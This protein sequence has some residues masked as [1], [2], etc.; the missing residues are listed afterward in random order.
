MRPL[1]RLFLVPLFI[2]IS[3]SI[4]FAQAPDWST[5]SSAG[6]TGSDRG[7]CVAMDAAG[8]SY[9]AGYFYEEATFGSITLSSS[10]YKELF[11]AKMAPNGVW[12]WAVKAG[13]S[14]HSEITAIAVD[15]AGNAY[16]TG[17]YH[18]TPDFG[19]HSFTSTAYGVDI[20]V[21]KINSSGTWQWAVS[22]GGDSEPEK[23]TD[24]ALDEA[25]N[26]YVTGFFQGTAAFGSTSLSS[27]G[28]TDIFIAKLTN[29]GTW[30]G[31]LG[32]GGPGPDQGYT[33]ASDISSNIFVSGYYSGSV[34]FG[35]TQLNSIGS[36]DIFVTKLDSFLSYL[37]AATASG[38]Y[39]SDIATDAAGSAYLSSGSEEQATFGSLNI[40]GGMFLIKID[41]SGAWTW[42]EAPSGLHYGVGQGIAIDAEDNIYWSGGFEG[43]VIFGS[44]TLQ[45]T[46]DD[47]ALF[48]AKLSNNGAWAWATQSLGGWNLTA[49]GLSVNDDHLVSI[50][51]GFYGS[52]QF[53]S[54]GLTAAGSRDILSLTLADTSNFTANFS[55]S[56]NNGPA[57]LTVT[58][59]DQS[60]GNPSSWQWDFQNDGV[61]DSEAQNP[62]FTYTEAGTFSVQLS[63]SNETNSSSQ[64]MADLIVVTPPFPIA[65]FD[66]DVLTGEAPLTVDFSDLSTGN[67]DSWSWDFETDGTIDSYEQNPQHQYNEV[68]EYSVSLTVT[69]A[70][71]SDSEV[72]EAYIVIT[73]PNITFTV[74]LDG[75]G[76]YSSI[77]SAIN[78]VSDG[79]IIVVYPGTYHEN[80]DLDGKAI[81]IE[82]LYASTQIAAHIDETIINGGANG[83]VVRINSG[84]GPDTELTGFTITN[85]SSSN[86]GGGIMM[87][88][89]SPTISNCKIVSNQATNYGGGIACL[90]NSN[91]MLKH[92]EVLNNTSNEGGGISVYLSNPVLEHVLV[93]NNTAASTGGG[94]ALSDCAELSIEH[95][96]ITQNIAQWG[97]G[98]FLTSSQF[99]INNSILWDNTPQEIYFND[100]YDPNQVGITY[101]DIDGGMAG[102]VV[103]N[104]TLNMGDGWINVHPFFNDGFRLTEYSPCIDAGDPESPLDPD[105]TRTDMGAFYYDPDYVRVDPGVETAESFGLLQNYP[106]PFNPSTTIRF[107]LPD[108]SMVTLVIYDIQGKVVHT[109][110]PA[111]KSAGWHHQL[112]NGYDNSGGSIGTGIYFARLTAGV[113]TQT[114]KMLHMK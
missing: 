36:T 110:G 102:I 66:A 96:T 83:N 22:A 6:G 44:S 113:H 47:E 43:D 82:S 16:V 107:S 30:L 78:G 70:S 60:I 86:T 88:G 87:Y 11:V 93:S 1:Y 64:L 3:F 15:A 80:I 75:T 20:F 52:P 10:L 72:K 58:F 109:Y 67:P 41:A 61:I 4:C 57:P 25:G 9:V 62:S 46:G 56:T 91:P 13:G 114:I 71:G 29:A 98:L 39:I 97:G 100:Y 69:N 35:S 68:G 14:N 28:D 24:L 21:A 8:N 79:H 73:P 49:E 85:G 12:L 81:R 34:T 54:Q 33:L 59:S 37:W 42:A 26:V 17:D 32:V 76:D 101:S 74:K 40:T 94:I 18:G 23:G 27:A 92:L 45:T 89:A 112:W 55:V 48:V 103:Q 51:G 38:A 111:L 84:E 65:E 99:T 63:I 106:N 90:Q 108:R 104:G 77:Q 95:L 5:V 53:G 7:T 31:A 2:A 19:G 105:N 50:A